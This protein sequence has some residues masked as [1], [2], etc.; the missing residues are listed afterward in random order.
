MSDR[1]LVRRPVA[2]GA[3]LAAFLAGCAVGPTYRAPET[4]L[5][6]FHNVPASRRDEA[7]PA[8][9]SWWTGFHDPMLVTVVERAL[10]QNLD[11]AGALARVQ[12]AR[13]AATV[14]RSRLLP[15]L[16]AG[17]SATAQRQSLESP[18]GRIASAFPGYDRSQDDYA[19]SGSASWEIDLF[20]GLRRGA[21]AARDEVQAAEAEQVGLRI[22]VAADAA[23]AYLQI[24][25]F[26]ARLASARAQVETDQKLLDL[27]RIQ[28]DAGQAD[29]REVAL[30][31][32]L[33]KQARASVQPLTIGLEAQLN[34]LDVLMGAQPGTYAAE[35]SEPRLTPS[36]PAVLTSL[37]PVEVLRRRPDVIAAERRL[38][39]SNER[40]GL[41]IAEFYPK[42]SLS[43]ALGYESVSA[44]SLFTSRAEQ[45][46]GAGVVRW[47]L[48][49]FG[50]LQA[51]VA[52]ARGANAEALAAYRLAVLRAVEDVEDALVSVSQLELH[53][54]DLQ[55]QV[56]ALTRA[57]QLSQI[58]YEAGSV[59]LTNVLEANRLL[60]AAQDEL[61]QTRADVGR[62]AVRTFRA[63]GGGW[64]AAPTA[65]ASRA[66][67]FG[68]TD[69]RKGMVATCFCSGLRYTPRNTSVRS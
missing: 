20:G 41:A 67:A 51:Q 60:L 34:R 14:A 21:L 53:E 4:R 29:D 12:Q 38:A 27:V 54:A 66:G 1:D 2:T 8:L 6:P 15:T 58:A 37:Q 39:A 49:D 13:A 26:Q 44:S 24:R 64:E 47:R 61:D 30:A 59:P 17:A 68:S 9:D 28:R 31:E 50:R 10:A 5:A 16:D 56:A 25:G 57:R 62:A 42:I 45:A 23:D 22:S 18:P 48:F 46:L 7:P 63:L 19:A 32:A 52:A 35:L 33:V 65:T 69:R 36:A 11:L 43:G 40:I 55:G 3:A